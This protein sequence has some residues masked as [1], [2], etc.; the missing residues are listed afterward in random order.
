MTQELYSSTEY[1]NPLIVNKNDGGE[2]Q[3]S[4][5]RKI[6][7]RRGFYLNV[8]IFRYDAVAGAI[9]NGIRLQVGLVLVPPVRTG[10]LDSARAASSLRAFSGSWP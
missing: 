4:F 1:I 2:I 10:G 3:F 9:I 6:S 5:S 8:G 7:H